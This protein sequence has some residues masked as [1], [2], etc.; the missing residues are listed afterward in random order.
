MNFDPVAFALGPQGVAVA[1][2]GSSDGGGA[3]VASAV[4]S[5]LINEGGGGTGPFLALPKS[6]STPTADDVLERGV[7]LGSGNY[8]IYLSNDNNVY[9]FRVGKNLEFAS[10][11]G[12]AK[13]YS[14]FGNG[15]LRTVSL[16]KD[17]DTG[18]YYVESANAGPYSDVYNCS[19]RSAG[20]VE[21]A[22]Y[23]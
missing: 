7:A 18:L 19:S 3:N 23:I 8:N 21:L 1:A 6:A 12:A 13:V 5:A 4:V 10:R 11:A 15:T 2:Q 20:L 9:Y 16:N 14:L 22:Q 17:N